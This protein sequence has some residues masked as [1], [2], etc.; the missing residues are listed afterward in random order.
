MNCDSNNSSG[1]PP[2]FSP[3]NDRSALLFAALPCVSEPFRPLFMLLFL[4]TE[5]SARDFSRVSIPSLNFSSPELF[6]TI[7][8]DRDTLLHSLS[9]YSSAFHTPLLQTLA[10]LLQAL[11]FYHIYKDLFSGLSSFMGTSD[12]NSA[13]GTDTGNTCRTKETSD[14]LS[15][16]LSGLGGLS[17]E[18]FQGMMSM[19]SES[20]ASATSD[21]PDSSDSA[22]FGSSG[23]S[24]SDSPDPSDQSSDSAPESNPAQSTSHASAESPASPQEPSEKSEDSPL[25]DN[26]YR[27]LTP[28]QQEIYERLMQNNSST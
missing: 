13:T 24:A 18:L 14:P 12:G 26:L 3:V 25:F 8:P 27:M 4:L 22:A 11:Q 16:I 17:P 28:S 6:D 20:S 7:F 21:S 9:F 15:G 1:N 10:N 2:I 5:F 19:F 23:S